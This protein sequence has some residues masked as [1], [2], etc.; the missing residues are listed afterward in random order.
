MKRQQG[1]TKNYAMAKSAK[2][3]ENTKET[4]NISDFPTEI[5]LKIF[6]YLAWIEFPRNF[7]FAQENL[8]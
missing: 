4:K 7:S 8:K 5:L 3:A 1:D 2:I 6:G